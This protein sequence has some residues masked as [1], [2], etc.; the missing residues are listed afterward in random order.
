MLNSDTFERSHRR[1]DV[2]PVAVDESPLYHHGTGHNRGEIFNQDTVIEERQEDDD[3]VKLLNSDTFEREVSPTNGDPLS[4]KGSVATR[5]EV[6]KE[7]IMETT[8]QEKPKRAIVPQEASVN[9][10]SRSNRETIEREQRKASMFFVGF[11]L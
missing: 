2:S 10:E 7:T 1:S 8:Q 3:Q 5:G 4:R 6:N 9:A 11:V